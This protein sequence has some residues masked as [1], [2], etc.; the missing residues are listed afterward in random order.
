[1]QENKKDICKRIYETLRSEQLPISGCSECVAAVALSNALRTRL[2][3][4]LD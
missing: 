4:K 2:G 3:N 1:M